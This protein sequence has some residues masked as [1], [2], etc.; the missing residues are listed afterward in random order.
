MIIDIVHGCIGFL[1]IKNVVYPIPSNGRSCQSYLLFSFDGHLGGISNFHT[2]PNGACF[3]DL[4]WV[5]HVFL[6]PDAG[7]IEASIP[8]CWRMDIPL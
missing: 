1:S 5:Q 2:Y 7:E 6:V 3:S 4:G 8:H